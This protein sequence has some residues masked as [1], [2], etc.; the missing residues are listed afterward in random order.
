MYFKG[1]VTIESF[2]SGDL[3]PD[4]LWLAGVINYVAILW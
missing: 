2:L 4:K 1:L 3:N